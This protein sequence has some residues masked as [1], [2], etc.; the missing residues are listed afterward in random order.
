MAETPTTR[1]ALARPAMLVA[2]LGGTGLAP[3]APGT[4]GSLVAAMCAWLIAEAAGPAWLVAG[5]AVLF[6][7]GWWAA[8]ALVA[9]LGEDPQI[10]VV[11]EAAGQFLTLA[12]APL[13]PRFYIAGFVLFRFFDVVKPWPVGWADRRIGGGFGVMLDDILAAL[14]AASVLLIARYFLGR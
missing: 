5:A 4:C 13:D 9:R 2:T 7:A 10:I 3:R 6:F 12:A 1:P 14:Y 11:D 8:S